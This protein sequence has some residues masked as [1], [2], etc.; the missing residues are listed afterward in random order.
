MLAQI[1][2]RLGARRQIL[3]PIAV[4]LD[5]DWTLAQE[6]EQHKHGDSNA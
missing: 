3:K 1:V 5:L 2:N 4:D 6:R